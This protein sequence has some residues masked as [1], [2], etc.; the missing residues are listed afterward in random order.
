MKKIFMLSF[1]LV[2]ATTLSATHH[3][4]Y[5]VYVETHFEQG[6]WKDADMTYDHAGAFL[7]PHQY[8]DLFGTVKADFYRKLLERLEQHHGF[9]EKVRL[10]DNE[11]KKVGH[12][13]YYDTLNIALEKGLTDAQLQ[14]ARNELTA[15]ILSAGEAQAVRL[16][17]YEQNRRIKTE[18][19]DY[20]HLD[21]PVFELVAMDE[22]IHERTRI[23]EKKV[24]DTVYQTRVDTVVADHRQQQAEGAAGN[25]WDRYLW[26]AII[27]VLAVYLWK[28]RSK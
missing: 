16:N 6:Y 12:R 13:E 8:T 1:F 7:Y 11:L 18:V 4:S 17:F 28:K 15:T 24:H 25:C 22:S 10:D 21:Y 3:L 23:V 14:T 20:S 27:G 5:F 26:L 2:G 9:Y 19:L